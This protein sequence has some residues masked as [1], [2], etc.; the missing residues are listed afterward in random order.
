MKNWIIVKASRVPSRAT[1]ANAY[2][3]PTAKTAGVQPA[4]VYSNREE[5]QNDAV[6]LSQMNPCGFLVLE[7]VE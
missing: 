7:V 3:G 5:A 1:V 4:K 6:K 2:G